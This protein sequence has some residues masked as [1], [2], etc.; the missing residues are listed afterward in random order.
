MLSYLKNRVDAELLEDEQLFNTLYPAEI[1]TIGGKHF[2]L[3]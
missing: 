1:A 3:I 2:C